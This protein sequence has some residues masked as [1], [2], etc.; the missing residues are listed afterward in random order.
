[1]VITATIHSGDPGFDPG[2][3]PPW[4]DFL[5]FPS[6]PPGDYRGGAT[7]SRPQPHTFL[8]LQFTYSSPHSSPSQNS[9]MTLTVEASINNQKNRL[10]QVLTE[11]LFKRLISLSLRIINCG[12]ALVSKSLNACLSTPFQNSCA[13]FNLCH[14]GGLFDTEQKFA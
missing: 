8:T 6:P 7:T 4:G 2:G 9:L 12:T 1:M 13:Y 3:R 11:W 14:P 10:I 5:W